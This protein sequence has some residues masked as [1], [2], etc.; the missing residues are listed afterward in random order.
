MIPKYISLLTL[1]LV[2]GSLAYAEVPPLTVAVY[3]FTGTGEAKS[4][5]ENVTALVTADLTADTNLVMVERAELNKALTELAFGIS[6]IVSS[7]AA[8]QIGQITGAKVLVAGQ[9][10][11]TGENQL[12][13]VADIIG[14]A[15]GRLFAAQVAGTTD[16]LTELT[17]NLS[18]KIAQI[19]ISQA[20]N[21]APAP[22]ESH[23]ERLEQIV[24]SIKGTN[25]PAVS[26]NF[27]WPNGKGH[28][29]TDETEFGIILLKAGFPVVDSNS[30]RKPD[31]EITG[32]DDTN[33]GP[34]RGGLLTFRTVISL[35]VQK[36]TGN[37]ITFDHQEGTGTDIARSS[38][39]RT[40]QVNAVDELAARVLPLLANSPANS[41]E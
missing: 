12:V 38:A 6:G 24:K 10:I 36:R 27:L 28:N 1:A 23:A 5:G 33:M 29:V 3:D 11:K 4:Y 41:K 19:I 39:A 18:R 31:V 21:L 26:V 9:V 16:N 40:A 7:D 14:T 25:R 13:I 15:T 2:A 20:T 35:K 8:A 30:D 37:I 22:E 32:I 34:R 17:S